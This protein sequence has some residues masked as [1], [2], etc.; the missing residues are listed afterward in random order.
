LVKP[1]VI[2]S[3]KLETLS[4]TVENRDGEA[5]DNIVRSLEN[6]YNMWPSALELNVETAYSVT[7]Y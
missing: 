3:I 7:A 1:S 5:V 4:Y 6:E 2:Q